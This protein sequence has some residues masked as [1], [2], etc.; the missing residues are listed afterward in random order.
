M[1][2]VELRLLLSCFR[3]R[4]YTGRPGE[5]SDITRSLNVQEEALGMLI[6]FLLS[7]LLLFI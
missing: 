4:I 7:D 5:P 2:K 6:I 3:C 1:A